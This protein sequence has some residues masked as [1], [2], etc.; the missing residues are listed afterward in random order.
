MIRKLLLCT[1]LV[2]L[3][4]CGG[5]GSPATAAADGL[6]PLPATVEGFLIVDVAEGDVDDEGHSD[7]NFGTLS[8][9]GDEVMIEVSGDLL[10]RAAIPPEGSEVRATLGSSS[11]RYG[12]T[13][14]TV[15]ALERR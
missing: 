14:Y 2:L 5:D 6:G 12:V 3:A 1:C 10:A 11:D 8:I 13:S 4:A 15:T 9:E 7:L